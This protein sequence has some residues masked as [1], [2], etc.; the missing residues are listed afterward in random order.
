MPVALPR[1]SIEIISRA[2]DQKKAIFDTVGDLK[3][4]KLLW[5][6]VLVA[7]YIR[8]ERT[9][10]SIIRP[11]DNVVEDLWQGKV[12]LMLKHGPKAYQD[13][14][15]NRF[16]GEKVEVGE[17]CAMRINDAWQCEINGVGCRVLEDSQIKM[18]IEDP[19]IVF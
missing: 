7:V 14:E 17:W 18:V 15:Y 12:G 4:V 9:T 19:T 3:G 10:G 16:N 5:N 1:K 2:V 8:P 13:D 6:L 11:F